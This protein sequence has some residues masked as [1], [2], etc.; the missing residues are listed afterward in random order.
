MVLRHAG[1]RASFDAFCVYL[2]SFL[3]IKFT[4]KIPPSPSPKTL[5]LPAIKTN[6]IIDEHSWKVETQ[7]Y[8]KKFSFCC[9]NVWSLNYLMLSLQPNKWITQRLTYVTDH[10][11][12]RRKNEVRILYCFSI[13]LKGAYFVL[14]SFL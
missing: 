11:Q 10:R 9:K 3:R 7:A 6:S 12:R 8:L 1:F 4:G 5:V 14:F 2:N 13:L